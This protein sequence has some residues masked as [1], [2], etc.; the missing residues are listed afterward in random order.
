M[1]PRVP[2]NMH[3]KTQRVL[4]PPPC[5]KCKYTTLFYPNTHPGPP[6]HHGRTSRYRT[7]HNIFAT[8]AML[9]VHIGPNSRQAPHVTHT[10]AYMPS[11][12]GNANSQHPLAPCTLSVG[13]ENRLQI[14]FPQ[15]IHNPKNHNNDHCEWEPHHTTTCTPVEQCYLT[16]T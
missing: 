12:H 7:F 11:N 6:V 16:R 9:G 4:P 15:N 8:S 5:T 1:L 10:N 2:F 13:R 14:A 3:N